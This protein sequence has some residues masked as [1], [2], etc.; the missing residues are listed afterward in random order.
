[1]KEA[2]IEVIL[3]TEVTPEYVKERNPDVLMIAIGAKE[4]RPPIKGI[5]GEN[6]IMAIDAELHPEKLGSKIVIMGEAL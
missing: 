2:D 5:D 1:M 3:N 6:V 4:S